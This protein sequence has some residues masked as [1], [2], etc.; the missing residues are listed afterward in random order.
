MSQALP[1]F[2]S[3]SA[4]RQATRHVT[5]F[6]DDALRPVGL[7]LNQ[8]SILAK[9]HRHGPQ[10]LLE[11]AK[12]LVM[13]RSTVGH[14]VRPLETRGLVSVEVSQRD[15][16]S[17]VVTLTDHGKAVMRR[18]RPLWANAERQFRKR[19]GHAAADGLHRILEQVTTTPLDSPRTRTRRVES[20][21]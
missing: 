14:L 18:A 17:R 13:D 1:E 5:R 21:Y 9:L 15:R 6:Y 11:L 8:Y 7:G 2:C 10:T 20:P 12:L 19:F 3:C 4:L 16:R